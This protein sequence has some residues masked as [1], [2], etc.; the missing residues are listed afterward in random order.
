MGELLT[1][2]FPGEEAAV[3]KKHIRTPVHKLLSVLYGVLFPVCNQLFEAK[4]SDEYVQKWLSTTHDARQKVGAIMAQIKLQHAVYESAEEMLQVVEC[5]F[6]LVNAIVEGAE[7]VASKDECSQQKSIQLRGLFISVLDT[8]EKLA[9]KDELCRSAHAHFRNSP[10]LAS[11]GKLMSKLNASVKK[12]LHA[13]VTPLVVGFG[14][15]SGFPS[16]PIRSLTIARDATSMQMLD[17]KAEDFGRACQ[18]ALRVHDGLLHK[19]VS[20]LHGVH[21][22]AKAL[23]AAEKH[24]QEK[25]GPKATYSQKKISMSHVQCLKDLRKA[26][27]QFQD[28]HAQSGDLERVGASGADH[29]DHHKTLDGGIL[30]G[31]IDKSVAE[32]VAR[33]EQAIAD[34]WT[35]GLMLLTQGIKQMCPSWQNHRDTLLDHEEVVQKLLTN[36]D[37]KKIGGLAGEITEAL[38]L[39]KGLHADNRGR[40]VSKDV[41]KAAKEAMTLGIETVAFT[42][43]CHHLKTVFPSITDLDSMATRVADVKYN[44]EHNHKV[45]LTDQMQRWCDEFCEGKRKG[46]S[47]VPALYQ[48]PAPA[49]PAVTISDAAPPTAGSATPSKRRRMSDAILRLMPS[50]EGEFPR[51]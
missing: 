8:A 46:T 4:A 18:V 20:Y 35:N 26:H 28:V 44:I 3:S 16:T 40:V 9:P 49:V 47:D 29:G 45:K 21:G 30:T 31:S 24:V 48:V 43:M 22:M 1:G 39:L 50:R 5:T 51:E 13:V 6:D 25:I 23:L 33:L 14:A 7:L 10:F 36:K 17:I 19:Q 27:K 11:D 38:T 15:F 34:A 42:Y 37:Y 12:E 2:A 41:A 32:E